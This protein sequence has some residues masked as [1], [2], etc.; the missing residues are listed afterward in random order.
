MHD[1][2]IIKNACMNQDNEINRTLFYKVINPDVVMD[3][4][5]LVEES[6][7]THELETLTILIR[8]LTNCLEAT[9]SEKENN[10]L[11]DREDIIRQAKYVLAIYAR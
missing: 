8:N 9:G 11:P 1:F 2:E 6:I 3:L 4:V 5:G 10:T 7:T